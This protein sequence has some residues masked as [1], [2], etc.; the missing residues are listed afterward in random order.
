MVPYVEK[1]V[2]S[3]CTSLRLPSA[4]CWRDI[5]RAA[6]RLLP[7]GRLQASNNVCPGGVQRNGKTSDEVWSSMADS[8]RLSE[9]QRG[10]IVALRR[11]YL[12]NLGVLS[13]RRQA[14]TSLLQARPI[15][16]AEQMTKLAIS[17]RCCCVITPFDSP[18]EC[19]TRCI[20][21]ASGHDFAYLAD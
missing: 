14:L 7:W 12:R 8:A 10:A 1:L 19:G 3:T 17:S 2:T 16:R 21:P 11:L 5:S 20:R 13:R 6:V 15:P 18:E 9:E 4:I